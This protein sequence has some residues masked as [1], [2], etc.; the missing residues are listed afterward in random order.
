[1]FLLTRALG[2][3]VRVFAT[4]IPL[5]IISSWSVPAGILATGLVTI[6]YT[7]AGGLRAVVWVDVVQLGF[8]LLG[9][10]VSLIVALDLAGGTAALGR[11]LAEGKLAVIDPTFSFTTT[12][13]LW[14]ARRRALLR[15]RRRHRALLVQRLLAAHDLRAARQR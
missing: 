8:Y 2:D 3:G 10:L 6:V 13:T 1:V 12:Y 14:G 9:G 11:A 7:W 4:A 5:A 15:R